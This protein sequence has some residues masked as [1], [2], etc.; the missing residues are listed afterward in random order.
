MVVAYL[1]KTLDK[2]FDDALAMVVL[3]RPMVSGALG[4]VGFSFCGLL[5]LC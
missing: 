4:S 2:S 1:M 3:K 5:W